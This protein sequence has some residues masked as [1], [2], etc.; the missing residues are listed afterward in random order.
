MEEARSRDEA[1]GRRLAV[2][3]RCNAPPSTACA[4][5]VGDRRDGAASFLLLELQTIERCITAALAQQFVVAARLDRAAIFDDVD[6]VGM[7]DGMKPMRD[8]KG[9][10]SLAE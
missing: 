5:G 9:G 1:A 4:L 2:R 3:I 7:R 10:A 6:A 8:R